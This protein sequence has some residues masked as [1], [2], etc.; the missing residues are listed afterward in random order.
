[1]CVC[2]KII[3]KLLLIL[4]KSKCIKHNK[5]AFTSISKFLAYK[6]DFVKYIYKQMYFTL[7]VL[8]QKTFLI[9]SCHI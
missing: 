2:V 9:S 7:H 5:Q 1:M 8:L 3:V 4:I 6:N